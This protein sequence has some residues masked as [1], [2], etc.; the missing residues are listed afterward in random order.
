MASRQ[1]CFSALLFAI[2]PLQE[3]GRSDHHILKQLIIATAPSCLRPLSRPSCFVDCTTL[4]KPYA[5]SLR[6]RTWNLP[7][8]LQ[9]KQQRKSEKVTDIK[10]HEEK[11]IHV[12]FFSFTSF[13]RVRALLTQ[14]VHR[15]QQQLAS[16][17]HTRCRR[18]GDRRVGSKGHT[19]CR[20]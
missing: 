7:G 6:S 5:A 2:K 20:I 8:T 1:H 12:N 16:V 18:V 9:E 3:L 11:W 19:R 17:K 10:T 13:P 14:E 15:Q 4:L